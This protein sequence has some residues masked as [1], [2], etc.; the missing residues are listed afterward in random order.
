MCLFTPQLSPGTHFSLPTANGLRLSR[1]GCLHG[2]EPRWF[3]RPKTVTHQGTN[4]VDQNQRVTT[5]LNRQPIR[6]V[7]PLSV[8][9][10]LYRINIGSPT[11]RLPVTAA[12]YYF[13]SLLFCNNICNRAGRLCPR[14]TRSPTWAFQRTHEPILGPM[15]LSDRKRRFVLHSKL[16][17]VPH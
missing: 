1:P 15:T 16:C 8:L 3:T 5:I 7:G 6:P 14:P 12:W 9:V 17:S 11:G 2:S 10:S 13:V 4:Y